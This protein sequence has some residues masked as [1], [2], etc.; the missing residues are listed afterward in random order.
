M[1]IFLGGGFQPT[2][3]LLPVA[4]QADESGFD[5]FAL[6]DHLASPA[7]VD[8]EYPGTDDG[9]VPW[10]IDVTPWPDALIALTAVAA[11]TRLDLMTHVYILPL[12][13]PLTVAK[14][15]G[16][17]ATLFPGRFHFGIGVGWMAEEFSLLGEDFRTRGR[18]ANEMIEILRTVWTLKPASH[19]GEQY[20]F[21]PIDM[22]PV[23]PV[24]PTILVGGSSDA[25]I[26]RAARIGDGFVAM[27]ATL[28][29]YRDGILPRI[30][31]S[32]DAQD[33]SSAGF[34]VNATLSEPIDALLLSELQALGVSSVQVHPFDRQV[35][36]EGTV[37]EKLAAVRSF[38][39]TVLA[40]FQA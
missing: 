27:P 34:H 13:H 14:S 38:G 30:Q 39:D 8:T 37:E 23:P 32:L 18:R 20:A 29:E 16:T 19:R 9:S 5:G 15:V 26:E 6:P 36:L 10:K 2:E 12:R 17:L 1:K 25:A 24:P 28:E 21:E 7:V 4:R 35:A 11:Q 40:Q 3:H 33:R 22:A 31:A